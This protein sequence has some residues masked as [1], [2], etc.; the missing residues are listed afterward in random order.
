MGLPLWTISVPLLLW[1]LGPAARPG[2]SL[3]AYQL[4][5]IWGPIVVISGLYRYHFEEFPWE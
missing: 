3:V 2:Q 5:R 1:L 4:E